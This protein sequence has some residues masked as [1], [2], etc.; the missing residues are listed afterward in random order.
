MDAKV[1][2]RRDLPDDAAKVV[3]VYLILMKTYAI[4]VVVALASAISTR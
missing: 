2:G 1:S 4:T 3:D